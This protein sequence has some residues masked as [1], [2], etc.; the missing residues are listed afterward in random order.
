MG[1]EG[2][3]SSFGQVA[4]NELWLN[5]VYQS[6]F[7]R[8]TDAGGRDVW[9]AAL[10]NGMS[11]AEI[12]AQIRQAKVNGSHAHG[13]GYVPFDGYVAELH[14]GERVLTAAE[15]QL[16]SA[17]P[18]GDSN[19]E[20]NAALVAEV[21]A[22]RGDVVSL[23]SALVKATGDGANAVASTVAAGAEHV[24]GSV[25][26]AVSRGAYAASERKVELV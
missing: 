25:G 1:A 9:L 4:Q 15:S 26:Q 21:R 10:G 18:R 22:L 2:A 3:K 8:A 12:E 5:S 17:T 11:Q 24:A 7:G 19:N 16:Y 6:V 14:Q 13:L 20:N 23:Q